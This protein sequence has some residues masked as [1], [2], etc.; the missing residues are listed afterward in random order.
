MRRERL[1]RRFSPRV[2]A[3][4]LALGCTPRGELVPGKAYPDS[5]ADVATLH[6]RGVAWSNTEIRAL[7]LGKVA[8]IGPASEQWKRDGVALPERAKRAFQMRHDARL[9]ARAMMADT[10]EEALLE[11]RDR[12]KYGTPDGPTFEWLMAHE[13]ERGKT[14][15]AAL[16]G[17]IES[18]QR[19]NSAVN[20]AL[21]L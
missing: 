5:T 13:A 14:G 10:R 2:P 8:A 7:Y 4:I 18:A 3:L 17:I 9:L 15:D 1:L 19:T 21:G 12:A 20:E 16:E 6:D 11:A